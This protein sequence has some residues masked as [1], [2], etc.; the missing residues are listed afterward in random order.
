MPSSLTVAGDDSCTVYIDGA[1]VVTNQNWFV[2]TKISVILT[3]GPHVIAIHGKNLVDPMVPLNP[4]GMII[5]LNIGGMKISSG[6]DWAVSNVFNG[7]W[8]MPNGKLSN[9]QPSST[10]GDIFATLWW[11]RDPFTFAAKNFP[12]DSKAMWIWSGSQNTDGNVYFRK[13]FNV[14]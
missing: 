11:N 10:Y 12:D 5:E 3:E 9:P 8:M 2:A 6:P 4:G 1:K 7:G 13:E 14:Q